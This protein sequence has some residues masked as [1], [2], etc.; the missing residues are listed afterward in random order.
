MEICAIPPVHSLLSTS[1]R[2]GILHCFGA[3][4]E[5]SAYKLMA[6]DA[7]F[8]LDQKTQGWKRGMRYCTRRGW[9][10]V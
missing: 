8:F 9:E 7:V 3:R 10:K 2:R 6:H 5:P 4:L 1:Y